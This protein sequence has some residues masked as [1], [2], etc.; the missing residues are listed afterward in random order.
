MVICQFAIRPSIRNSGKL[1]TRDN[2]IKK[3]AEIVG[4]EHK[5][6]LSNPDAV[7]LVEVYKVITSL[8]CMACRS[9][10]C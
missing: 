5:V 8:M 1:L 10:L 4:A 7:I 6:D 9:S 2:I 3:V